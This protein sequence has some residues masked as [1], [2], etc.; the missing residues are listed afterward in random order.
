MAR[1]SAAGTGATTP[2]TLQRALGR[3]DLTAVGIN[4]V[5]GGGIFLVPSPVAALVGAYAPFV[6]LLVGMAALLIALCFA[7]VG[8]RFDT[9]GGPYLYAREA[10]GRF[11]GFEV[12]WIAW[13]TRAA[14]QASV[15]N[16]LVLALG[17]YW[18]AATGPISRP[19][20]ITAV[21]TI[22][23]FI[24]VRGIRPT[25]ATLVF[26]RERHQRP[27]GALRD[28]VG[29]ALFVAPLGPIIPVTACVVSI[30][31]IAAASRDQLLAGALAIAGGAALFGLRLIQ[32]RLSVGNETDRP[33]PGP[34]EEAGQ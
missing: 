29:P 3:W 1:H 6:C 21:T 28:P 26:R 32:S 17:F 11:A 31:M 10:F 12:G 22:L 9:T 16:G 5:I 15:V 25:A 14:A 4:I 2:P 7:E 18:P 13:F 20:I 23:V 19:A 33:R 34:T 27:A 8:S 30:A 24:N